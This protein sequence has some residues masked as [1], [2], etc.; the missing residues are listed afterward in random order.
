VIRP[1]LESEAGGD[2]LRMFHAWFAEARETGIELPEAVA[3]ATASRSGAPSARMVLLKGADEAGLVFF[4][5]Y[6]SRKSR[7]LEANPLAAL[8]FHWQALG[9][10]VRVEG[11]VARCSR[12]ETERYVHSRP[13]GSQL[14]ALASPQS[15]V[16][17]SRE[18]LE[19]RV[20]ELAAR[21]RDAEPP[22]PEDWGG[23]RL[24]PGEWEFWQHREDRLHDRLRYRPAPEGGWRIERLGP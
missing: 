8:L 24:V 15:Q 16:V 14:S 19:G 1:L 12:D 18:A 13:R 23:Y 17:E 22:V 11:A 2:P 3:L 20:A 21:Y 9:R 7:E 4:T 5:S 10:Q 6:Q